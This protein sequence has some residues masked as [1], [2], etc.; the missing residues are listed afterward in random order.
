ASVPSMAPRGENTIRDVTPGGWFDASVE[1][2]HRASGKRWCDMA[3]SR[4]RPGRRPGRGTFAKADRL[5][6]VSTREDRGCHR[7]CASE[8]VAEE[9]AVDGDAFAG[10]VTGGRHA[11][12]GHG[13]GD[14]LGLAH[15]P[16]RRAP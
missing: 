14:F 3:K 13:G 8:S 9:A 1:T 7:S 12:E 11:Q 16:H 4:R 5:S 15:T 6:S 10:D 2:V